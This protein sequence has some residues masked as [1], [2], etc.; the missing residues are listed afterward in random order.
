MKRISMWSGPRNISTAFMYSF[1][2]RGDCFV[3]DEPYYAY[4]LEKT[5]LNHPCRAEILADQENDADL[6]TIDLIRKDFGSKYLFMKNM[7]HHMVDLD[8]SFVAAFEN[9]FLIREP[10]EMILSYIQKIPAPNMSDLGLDM[11]FQLFESLCEAGITPA[12][13][14]SF[15]L[16]SNP[17]GVLEDLCIRLGIPFIEK[18]I[19]WPAGAI[20]Q[21]GVWADYWYANVHASQGFAPAIKRDVSD[22]PESLESLAQECEYYYQEMKKH[23]WTP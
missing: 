10:R 22:F 7:P 17:R 1:H 3:I 14:D 13:V 9:F 21:D 19:Q 23:T 16:L 11:Q 18:M 15:E 5:G 4:Y 20:E 8:L 2:H 12:V 6:V